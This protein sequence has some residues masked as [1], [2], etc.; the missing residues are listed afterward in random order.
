VIV[1]VETEAA[2]FRGAGP[3]F[4]SPGTSRGGNRY[5]PD[6]QVTFDVAPRNM[7]LR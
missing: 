4:F 7:V 6:M 3:A 1:R 2:E 5:N